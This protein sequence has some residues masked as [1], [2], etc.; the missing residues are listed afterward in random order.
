MIGKEDGECTAR[1]VRSVFLGV[2]ETD[3]VFDAGAVVLGEFESGVSVVHTAEL[4]HVDAN[5]G[6]GFVISMDTFH[7]VMKTNFL[8]GEGDAQS[9]LVAVWG[10]VGKVFR[11]QESQPKF[12]FR[13]EPRD[14][15]ERGMDELGVVDDSIALEVATKKFEAV[16]KADGTDEV[17]QYWSKIFA[18]VGQ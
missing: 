6:S 9:D 1:T 11:D 18:L 5:N 2:V 15:V 8:G 7:G 16:K 10:I 14:I 4:G 3:G 17:F 12:V 13:I